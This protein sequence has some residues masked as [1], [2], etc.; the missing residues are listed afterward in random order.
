MAKISKQKQIKE[1]IK[2]GKAPVYFVNKYVK[3][4]HPTNMIFELA[5]YD[6]RIDPVATNL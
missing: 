1:I 5:E 3:I 2:C 4:Q 6:M